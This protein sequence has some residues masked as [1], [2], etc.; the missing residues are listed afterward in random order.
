MNRKKPQISSAINSA[1]LQDH[2]L[3]KY[4][5]SSD[6]PKRPTSF[7][8]NAKSIL[9]VIPKDEI[10]KK[11]INYNNKLTLAQRLGLVEKPD[12]PLDHDQ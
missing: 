3:K 5:I 10:M 1:A 7:A 4:S 6:L 2:I 8:R 9:K 12:A 11:Q